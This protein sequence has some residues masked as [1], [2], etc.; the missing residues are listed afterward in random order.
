MWLWKTIQIKLQ[1][2]QELYIA[3][4]DIVDTQTVWK[5]QTESEHIQQAERAESWAVISLLE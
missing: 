3:H 4:Q 2:L 1:T 5:G